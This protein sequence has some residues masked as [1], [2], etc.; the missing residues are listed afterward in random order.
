MPSDLFN[1]DPPRIYVDPLMDHGWRLGPSCHLLCEPGQVDALH[2]FAAKIGMKRAWFQDHRAMPHYDLVRSRRDRA[3]K[4]GAIEL[5]ASKEWLALRNRW[6]D[7][8]RE[9]MAKEAK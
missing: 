6:R 8:K 9:Q 7:Y 3:V 1:P 2:E 4:L 5:P